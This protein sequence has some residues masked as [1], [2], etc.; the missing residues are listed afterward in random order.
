MRVFCATLLALTFWVGAQCRAALAENRFALLIGNQA[1][2]DGIYNFLMVSTR[3]NPCPVSSAVKLNWR[4]CGPKTPSP[5]E[6]VI[7]RA[8][9]GM[10][11]TVKRPSPPVLPDCPVSA[12]TVTP[13]TGSPAL[14]VS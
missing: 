4:N 1:Y 12:A 9:S 3:V 6:G 13:E 7:V 2:N 10:P 8:P 11:Q 14:M 5:N